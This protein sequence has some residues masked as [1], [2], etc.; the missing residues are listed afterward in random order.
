MQQVMALSIPNRT[1]RV[2]THVF[3]RR[4]M[5]HTEVFL[6]TR[7]PPLLV[8]EALTSGVPIEVPKDTRRA[9]GQAQ[10]NEFESAAWFRAA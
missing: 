2:P 3:W 4:W 9:S 7:K 10:A 6:E 5:S 1:K 8:G